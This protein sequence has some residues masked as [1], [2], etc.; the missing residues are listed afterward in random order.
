MPVVETL[1]I[2]ALVVAIVAGA[3]LIAVSVRAFL[4]AKRLHELS[5]QFS[6]LLEREVRPAVAE[7]AET[8]RGLQRA[9]GKMESAITPIE[10]TVQKVERWV[11]VAAEAVVARAMSPTFGKVVGVLGG[12][13]RH[14]RGSNGGRG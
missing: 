1:T 2:L 13:L 11:G 6:E 9:A 12:L 7:V 5:D 10:H 4:L 8:A 3:A 14:G